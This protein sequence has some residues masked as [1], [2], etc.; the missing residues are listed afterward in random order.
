MY[1]NDKP[2]EPTKEGA[3]SFVLF[4]SPFTSVSTVSRGHFSPVYSQL[5]TKAC[6][7]TNGRRLRKGEVEGVVIKNHTCREP[8][9]Y[10]VYRAES[11]E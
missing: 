2:N 11:I 4:E 8:N 7:W 5:V 10:V 3:L 1:R 6:S 9:N